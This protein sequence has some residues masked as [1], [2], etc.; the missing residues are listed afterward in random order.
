[1]ADKRIRVW[2]QEFPDRPHLVLQWHDPITGK[3]R[4]KTAGTADPQAA[5]DKRADLESDLNNNR[6][7]EASRMSWATFRELFETQ[8]V[9]PL[10]EGTR[11]VHA[12]TLDSFEEIC[13]PT[14]LRAAATMGMANRY[15]VGLRAKPGRGPD[16]KMSAPTIFVRLEFLH[17]AFSW[18]RV[19]K[20]IP[21]V[22]TF[23]KV[24]VPKKRPQP[25]AEELVERLLD[26]A[27]DDV[28]MAGLLLCMWLA[29]LRRNEAM[30]L[31]RQESDRH[32][33]VD[34]DNCR[35]RLP[36]EACK[37]DKDDWVPLHPDLAEALKAVPTTGPRVFRFTYAN[38]RPLTPNG[39]TERIRTLAR[40]AGVR[41]NFRALRRGFAC[42]L[43]ASVPAQ[44]L[45]KLM[46]HSNINTTVSYYANVDEAAEKAILALG[47]NKSRNTPRKGEAGASPYDAV[48]RSKKT[49]SVDD[50]SSR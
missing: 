22:P 43:A 36:A 15:L 7:A 31:R 25:V 11:K 42:R 8:Y 2:V 39:L 49:G 17:T 19:Q 13:K 41:L 48:K 44:V 29:G 40:S 38:G 33:W 4:S 5:E 18:A 24:K 45:Q 50:W 9:A 21:A 16:G 3:R 28:Q 32:P 30:E 27:A 14:T 1:M 20:L 35:I 23:P 46:R 34:F 6:H 37:G 12:T 10:R 47:R 26:A